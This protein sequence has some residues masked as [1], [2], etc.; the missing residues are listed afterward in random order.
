MARLES[1]MVPKRIEIVDELPQ[2]E[3]G[4]IRHASLR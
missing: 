2:T 3:S 1:Y 4:K